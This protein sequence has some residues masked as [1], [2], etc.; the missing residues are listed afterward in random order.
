MSQFIR[1]VSVVRHQDETFRFKIE[2]TN[3]KKRFRIRNETV[4]G[5]ASV[6]FNPVAEDKTRFINRNIN[7]FRFLV[8]EQDTVNTDLVFFGICLRP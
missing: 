6:V 2:P 4:N 5:L 8:I 1:Q 3:D 7:L